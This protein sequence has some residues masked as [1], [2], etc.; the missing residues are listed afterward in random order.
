MLININ[1]ITVDLKFNFKAEMLFEAINGTSFTA[2]TTTEWIQEFFCFVIASAGD[3]AIK[4]DDFLE[5]LNSH[6]EQLYEFIEWYTKE[7]GSIN[8]TRA[9]LHQNDD[10]KKVEE[11]K[12]GGKKALK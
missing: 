1:D 9:S 12:T 7:I 5:W 6:P 3:G 11:K 10:V 4:F 8:D 2:Q